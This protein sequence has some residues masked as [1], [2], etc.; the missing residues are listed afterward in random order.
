[1]WDR[2]RL[3]RWFLHAGEDQARASRD[4]SRNHDRYHDD[5]HGFTPWPDQRLSEAAVLPASV[6]RF[7]DPHPARG[8]LQRSCFQA[9][10]EDFYTDARVFFIDN[11]QYSRRLELTIQR[12]SVA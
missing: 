8:R 3:V 12:N 1:V 5:L 9:H 10:E 2:E 7:F 6:P 4:Q 11:D